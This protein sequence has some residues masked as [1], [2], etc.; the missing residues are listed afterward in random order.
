MITIYQLKPRFQ[1]LLRPGVQ[2]LAR[3]GTTANQVTLLAC[4]LSLQPGGASGE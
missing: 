1:S 3:R 2:A 4:G